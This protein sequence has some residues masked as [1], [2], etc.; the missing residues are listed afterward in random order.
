MSRDD[1]DP[2]TRRHVSRKVMRGFEPRNLAEA[3]AAFR[4]GRGITH[5]EL[6]RLSGVSI[7]AIRRWEEGA[8]VP[9]VDK[10]L[11]VAQVLGIEAPMEKLISIPRGKRSPADW[12]ALF[13]LLQPTVGRI[14]GIETSDVSRIER[15][16][17]PP[18][19]KQA[20]ALAA[21]YGITVEE[22]MES[23]QRARMTPLDPPR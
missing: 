15:G 10:L 14:A 8:A 16:I 5:S 2:T 19:P 18:T 3:R 6:A 7:T 1:S 9:Q 20:L 4:D 12:R 22:F 17:R 11:L 21:V 23:F 13:G